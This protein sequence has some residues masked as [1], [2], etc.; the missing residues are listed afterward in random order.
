VSTVPQ[1]TIDNKSTIHNYPIVSVRPGIGV[2]YLRLRHR[3]SELPV[4]EAK[5]LCGDLAQVL[6]VIDRKRNPL[7]DELA[8]AILEDEVTVCLDFPG[9]RWA[10]QPHHWIAVEGKGET[11]RFLFAKGERIEVN[12]EDACTALIAMREVIPRVLAALP[13]DPA[14]VQ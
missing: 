6:D 2:V 12:F 5:A 9:G 13:A 10:I 3:M 11:V 7:T 1:L 4:Y 14:S 8:L